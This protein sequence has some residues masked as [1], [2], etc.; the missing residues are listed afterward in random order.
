MTANLG[1]AGNIEGAPPGGI[2][3][4]GQ[5]LGPKVLGILL[6]VGGVALAAYGT[7]NLTMPLLEKLD[8]TKAS[9]ATKEQAIAQKQ[10]QINSKADIQQK[11]DEANQK[12]QEVVNLLPSPDNM[13]TLLRDLNALLPAKIV[14]QSPYATVQITGSLEEFK[15]STPAAGPDDRKYNQRTFGVQFTAT[16]PDALAIMRKIEQLKPLL[17]TRNLKLTPNTNL[18][19]ELSGNRQLTPDQEKA[20]L[21]NLPPLL[22]A[23]FDIVTYVPL[24]QEEIKAQEEKAKAAEAAANP[25][26]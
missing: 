17:V 25:P 15:P 14:L 8:Q 1:A 4:F 9:I 21:A 24:S 20:I 11:I 6:G 5:T 26:K 16:Y 12:Y 7:F 13:D 18:K 10:G 2:V 22:T 3:L 23:T 19:A